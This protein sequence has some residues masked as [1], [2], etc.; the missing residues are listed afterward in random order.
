M[1]MRCSLELEAPVEGLV[2]PEAASR[3]QGKVLEPEAQEALV[4]AHHSAALEQEE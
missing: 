2:V 4:A 3:L 1:Q